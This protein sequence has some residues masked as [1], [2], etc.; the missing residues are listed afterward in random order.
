MTVITD[1]PFVLEKS[2]K[3]LV[4]QINHSIEIVGLFFS[5][6]VTLTIAIGMFSGEESKF[7]AFLPG[8]VG[9][10]S[11][12]GGL[13]KILFQPYTR[14]IFDKNQNLLIVKKGRSKSHCYSLEHLIVSVKHPPK[15]LNNDTFDCNILSNTHNVSQPEIPVMSFS[16]Q[17]KA[18]RMESLIQDYLH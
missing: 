13:Q 18:Y 10:C 6:S 9:I 1:S 12:L 7:C 4:L 3:K 15:G 5:G 16:N 17:E 11:L 2:P 14:Y 8:I